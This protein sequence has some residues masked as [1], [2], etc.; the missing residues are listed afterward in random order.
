MLDKKPGNRPSSARAVEAILASFQSEQAITLP[1]LLDQ[2]GVQ[3]LDELAS[4]RAPE[5]AKWNHEW[6]RKSYPKSTI[7]VLET[8]EKEQILANRT[9]ELAKSIQHGSRDFVVTECMCGKH[10]QPLVA[11]GS[12]PP[13]WYSFERQQ[14]GQ[15]SKNS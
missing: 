4:S 14:R 9:D 15:H 7:P 8:G 1:T 13:F 3:S 12:P 5:R 2:L 10:G 11:P 6:K